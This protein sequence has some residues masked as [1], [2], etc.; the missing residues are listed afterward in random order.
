[1][2]RIARPVEVPEVLLKAGRRQSD[3]ICQEYDRN[4]EDYQSGRQTLAFDAKIYGHASVKSVLV[5]AQHGKCCYCE[6]K[7]GA[8]SYG[9]VEH[10]R[11]KGAVQQTK[12]SAR[13]VPGYYW[14][15]FEWNNLLVSCEKCN[16]SYKGSL[17][18]L[19]NP[20]ARA[21]SHKDDVCVERSLFV[22]PSRENPREHIQF[23]QAAVSPITPRGRETIAGAGLR[24]SELEEARKERLDVVKLLQDIVSL[25]NK[26]EQSKLEKAKEM[27]GFYISVQS[28]FSAMVQDFVESTN[29]V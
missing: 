8:T 13:L 28:E 22:D 14:L 25:K 3:R 7:F 24:R 19:E 18:P 10:F 23:R 15:A 9:A 2:I 4:P 5:E 12:G 27:L 1:M 17:F 21:R 16:T 6:R 11:P 20:N 26:F 29:T